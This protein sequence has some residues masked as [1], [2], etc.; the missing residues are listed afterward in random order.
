[1]RTL[2]V[3]SCALCLLTVI[4]YSCLC[5]HVASAP[6]IGQLILLKWKNKQGQEQRLRIL[7]EVCTK[8]KDIGGVIG[9]NP[10]RLD[11]I[12]KHRLGDMMECCRDV[13]SVWLQQEEGS[14]PVTWDGVHELLKDMELFC[15]AQKLEGFSTQ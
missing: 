7:Q 8:W 11:A 1:M 14:Y 2:Y 4:H 9:L 10:S 13:F 5:C 3:L 6:T 12:E 15:I